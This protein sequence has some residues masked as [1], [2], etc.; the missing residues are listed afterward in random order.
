MTGHTSPVG[1]DLP[2]DALRFKRRLNRHSEPVSLDLPADALRFKREHLLCA[3]ERVELLL[4]P[5]GAVAVCTPSLPH[6]YELNLV[7]APVATGPERAAAA[8]VE[9]ELPKVRLDGPVSGVDFPT[10]WNVDREIMMVRRRA[11]DRPPRHDDAVRALSL[12]ELAPSEDEMLRSVSFARDPEVRRQL[13]AQGER[14][15]A[16]AP[17]VQRL[18]IVE[19]GRVVAWCRVYDDGTLAEIDGVGVLPA[20]RGRGLGRALMEGVLARIPDE[21]TVFLIAERDDWPRRLYDRLG[22]DVVGEL[23][24]ATRADVLPAP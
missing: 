9:L 16:A 21:R 1:L 24:G 17:D 15:D 2:A 6:V 12:A 10:G 3:A 19:D 7:L 8:C 20:A 4:E 23:V 5:P 14:W 22:F 18:G 11:S 13:V